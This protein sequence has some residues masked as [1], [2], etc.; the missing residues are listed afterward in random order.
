MKCKF[1]ELEVTTRFDAGQRVWRVMNFP[2]CVGNANFKAIYNEVGE[3]HFNLQIGGVYYTYHFFNLSLH[4]KN[5]FY[6]DDLYATEEEAQAVAEE[7]QKQWTI[8]Y[9]KSKT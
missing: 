2:D 1:G 8:T 9:L 3:I 4:E 5:R 7:R 6:Q